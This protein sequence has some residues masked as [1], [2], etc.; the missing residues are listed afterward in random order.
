M[1]SDESKSEGSGDKG[2]S[3]SI[4]VKAVA[5]VFATVVAPVLIVLGTK[6]SDVLV[7]KV[8]A[9]AEPAKEAPATASTS[10]AAP[11][12]APGATPAATASTTPTETPP[13]DS[14]KPAQAAPATTFA[15]AETDNKSAGSG[16]NDTSGSSKRGGNRNRRGGAKD[17]PAETTAAP[18]KSQ[19]PAVYTSVFNGRDLSEWEAVGS[20][21]DR[22][23]VGPKQNILIGNNDTG[24]KK[25][26]WLYTKKEY[27]D[28]RLRFDFRMD[29]ETD[30]GIALR[31]P[32]AFNVKDGRI[33]I[34][35]SNDPKEPVPTGTLVTVSGGNSHPQSSPKNAVELKP[36]K[37]WNSVEIELRGPQLH[38]SF[39]G[40]EIQDVRLDKL[41]GGK[42]A[43]GLQAKTGRIGLE[44]RNGRIEFRKVEMQELK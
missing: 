9:P 34:I 2:G 14:G 27:A 13:K 43:P 25:G 5:T 16:A 23:S 11:A 19:I 1:G 39:N 37:A 38:V 3:N 31:T 24:K 40:Q 21:I 12:A 29:P 22:W 32:A 8:S 10:N 28:F 33:T 20:D 15:V 7:S 6:F 35:L 4:V 30:S 41:T 36:A 42:S 44:C 26:F 17:A 18:E